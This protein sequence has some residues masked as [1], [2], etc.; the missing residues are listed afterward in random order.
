T[1]TF[2]GR[3]A[4]TGQSVFANLLTAYQ[5]ITAPNFVATSSTASVFPYA[6]STAITVSGTASTTNLIVSS[7]AT[8]GNSCLYA[9]STGL[10]NGTG[11]ACGG[12][13]SQWDDVTGGINYAGGKVGIGSSTPFAKLS[14]DGDVR[15]QGENFATT[16]IGNLVSNLTVGAI[17]YLGGKIPFLRSISSAGAL[18]VNKGSFYIQEDAETNGPA[19]LGFIS[20][21]LNI[22]AGITFST[23]TGALDISSQATTTANQGF[24]I[25]NGCYA[26]DGVCISGGGSSQWT[27]NGDNVFYVN[28]NGGNAGVLNDFTPTFILGDSTGASFAGMSYSTTSDSLSFLSATGGYNF[29]AFINNTDTA[30][31]TFAG[32]IQIANGQRLQVSGIDGYSPINI[33]AN[34]D[35]TSLATSTFAN[36]ITLTTGCITVG[37]VCI[38]GY[39]T[40]SADYWL[41]TKST[42]NLT[43]GSRLYWTDTR[44]DNR[45]SASSSISGITTL[46]NLSLPATQLSGFGGLFYTF[47]SATT[48][49]ALTEGS[50]NKYWSNTLFDNRLSATTSLPNLITLG[51]LSL[52]IGQVSG[53]GAGVGTF[54]ATPSSANLD[55]AVTDDTGSGALVFATSPTLVTPILGTPQSVD[56]TNAT[57]L[58]LSTGVTGDLPFANLTQG[59]ALSVLGVTGNATADVSS[60]AAGSDHQVLRRSG[61]SVAFG[62]INLAQS[63]AVTGILDET[64]GGTGQSTIT[65]GDLL[66][67]SASN[68]LSKLAGVATGNAL[69]S[70]GVSTAPAWGKIGLTTH[71][72]GTLPIA[73]GGTNLT[74]SA[75]DNV[76]VG[77]G[78]TWQT[79]ALTDC[80]T[81]SSALT[82]DTTA[83][84]FGCNSIAGSGGGWTDYG[85][86][87]ELTT[88]TDNIGAGNS[89]S[90]HA[91]MTVSDSVDRP[92]VLNIKSNGIQE[93][94]RIEFNN[95]SST[96]WSTVAGNFYLENTW[97]SGDIIGSMQ[98]NYG[99]LAGVNLMTWDFDP[100][101]LGC[102]FARVGINNETPTAMLHITRDDGEPDTEPNLELSSDLAA[103]EPFMVFSQTTTDRATIKYEDTGDIL[104]TAASALKFYTNSATPITERLSIDASGNTVFNDLAADADFRIE[105]DTDTEM[106]AIDAGLNRVG[107][108]S[109][110][111]F[112]TFSV[113]G[114]IAFNPAALTTNTGAS[115]YS[116]CLAAGGEV[117]K[118]T[119]AE[120]CIASSLRYKQNVEDLS[121]SSLLE[122]TQLRPVTFEYKENGN[123]EHI[124]FIAEEAEQ[125]NPLLVSYDELGLP[126]GIRWS[127]ITT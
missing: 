86:F 71:V 124:G 62:S 98:M 21:D 79:K 60:I 20:D 123:G 127:H 126:N 47:F 89:T 118:N 28:S 72:S 115:T 114:T 91:K 121:G 76:M 19:T 78:T 117:T 35:V 39:S 38:G 93:P 42:T 100:C 7:L 27:T 75:D 104:Q 82:Y 8:A 51:S 57:G 67:G 18:L 107:I 90:T 87:V 81:A 105:S 77:N 43:E 17:D 31:S 58:P 15:F 45:L 50:I 6:S 122:I 74:A 73:N 24:D 16:T 96:L 12:G 25:S 111:P 68:V 37:G 88:A 95:S 26:V 4:V 85:S 49:D 83:N 125:V 54:L 84:A 56:L 44:F 55:T 5:T 120:T 3:L 36:G 13:G 48:T 63:A 34:L 110:T 70:G 94:A 116:L 11:S 61:T 106:F 53:L 66:Y 59:S 23:T 41:T 112:K 65:T 102:G 52:P 30:T 113:D 22:S 14:V 69:I 40:T 103:G 33:S 10:I 80:D 29:D 9:D 46:P 101:G 108:S 1:T 97:T 64:N 2:L 92:T 99:G 119:D 109:T 32:G